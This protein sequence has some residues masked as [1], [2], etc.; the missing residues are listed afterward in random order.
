MADG[1]VGG[2]TRVQRRA[3]V[4][5]GGGRRKKRHK[6]R[7]GRRQR[8]K[9]CK[10]KPIARTCAGK[11]GMLKNTCKKRIDC[12]P[13]ACIPSTT[14]PAGSNCGTRD[15]GC[16]TGTHTCGGE[17][18]NPTP[19]CV[20]NV[21][22]ACSTDAPCPAGFV[23]QAGRCTACTVTCDAPNHVCAG[24]DLQAKL[25]A[26]G[27]VAVCPGRYTLPVVN[28][29]PTSFTLNANVTVIGAGQGDDPA[30][31]TIL[32]GEQRDS[33]V[34]VAGGVT[35]AL[36]G[37]RVTG[38]SAAGGGGLFSDAGTL[39]LTACTV[40]GNTFVG[41][42]GAAGGGITNRDGALTL[43]DS[44]V[45]ENRAPTGEGGGI[46]QSNAGTLTLINSVVSKNQSR[47]VQGIGG[48]GGG[49]SNFGTITITATSTITG[50]VA[51]AEGGGI[52]NAGT[53]TFDGSGSVTR[54]TAADGGGIFNS[55]GNVTLNSSS[56]TGNTPNNCAP[57]NAVPGCVG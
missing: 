37:L 21:C 41:G 15:N 49:I 42:L 12:G 25:D 8:H 10:A 16:G 34:F 4:G 55:G 28:N 23:C 32:D 17:C 40:I 54:N 53:I 30:T 6:H 18:R 46:F 2:G 36:E 3:G 44:T 47:R 48:K 31:S 35:A 19:V 22:T 7:K 43:I 24:A 57:A 20:A 9:T 13:C 56:V 11:C 38:G 1:A 52:F 26:G 29:T 14:C 39:T 51:D 45:T 5:G 33:V 27:T 50:N